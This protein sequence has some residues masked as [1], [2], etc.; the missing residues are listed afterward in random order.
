MVLRRVRSFFTSPR[1]RAEVGAQR[2]VRGSLHEFLCV[3]YSM[4]DAPHPNPLPV[5]TGRGSA[6]RKRR[7]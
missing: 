7:T 4:I 1:V 3:L 6:A 2:R 5:R